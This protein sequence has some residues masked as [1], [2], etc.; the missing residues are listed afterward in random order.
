MSFSKSTGGKNQ[1]GF[2]T[3][4]TDLR[5]KIRRQQYHSFITNYFKSQE[6]QDKN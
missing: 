1:V 2:Y 4:F 3:N 5:R 6:V